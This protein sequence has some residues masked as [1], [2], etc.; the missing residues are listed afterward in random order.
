MY[1]E[2]T[3]FFLKQCE[4]AVRRRYGYL[5]I[6]LKTTTQDDCRLR[7]NGLPGKE[8]FNQVEVEGN[9]PQEYLRYLKQQNLSTDPHLPAMQRLQS[10]MDS[11][12]AVTSEKMRRL[13]SFFS[14][15]TD[16]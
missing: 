1:P 3:E 4:E 7:T 14:C 2:R 15:K 16:T 6:D 9:I 5:L 13:N 8:G 12:L 11:T 10:G